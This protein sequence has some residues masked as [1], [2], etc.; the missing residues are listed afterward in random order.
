VEKTTDY[1][2]LF[3][4]TIGITKGKWGTL[5]NALLDF[6]RDFDA[7]LAL[8]RA[9]PHL[10]AQSPQRYAKLGLR[11]LAQQMHKQI[12]AS[13]QMRW[14]ARAVTELPHLVIRPADAY[15]HLVRNEVELLPLAEMNN[16]TVATG[17]VPYPPGIPLLMPGESAGAQDGPHLH[18]L[19][20][21]EDWDRSFPGFEYET[22][23]VDNERGHYR[24]WCLTEKK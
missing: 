6:K 22:H 11:D 3:L 7:N 16:R 19:R 12:Q 5:V 14:Q 2:I 24:V 1:T 8:D 20:T 9:I 4:F 21:L 23:G 15:Q 17:V 18:Y 10:V 13:Q